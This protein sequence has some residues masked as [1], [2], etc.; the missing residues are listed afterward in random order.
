EP[1]DRLYLAASGEVESRERPG[2]GALEQ[3]RP[4]A[5]LLPDRIAP[6]ARPRQRAIGEEDEVPRILHRQRAQQETVD[7]G[8]DG[9]VRTDAERERQDRDGGDDGCRAQGSDGEATVVNE[10]V[11]QQKRALIADRLLGLHDAAE[12][13][14]R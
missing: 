1:L 4:L 10:A 11:H 9:G 8:E 14:S 7:E 6:R 13:Q 12:L 3:L 5:D 2:R